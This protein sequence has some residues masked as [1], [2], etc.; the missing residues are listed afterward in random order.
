VSDGTQTRDHLDH[1]PRELA[2]L[3]LSRAICRDSEG[4]PFALAA[5]PRPARDATP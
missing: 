1:N 2:S 4:S 3:M 5:E